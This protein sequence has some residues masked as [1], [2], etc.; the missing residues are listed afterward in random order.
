MT[1]GHRKN[2]PKT[3]RTI[4]PSRISR[5]A[6]SIVDIGEFALLAKKFKAAAKRRKIVVAAHASLMEEIKNNKIHSVTISTTCVDEFLLLQY[7]EQGRPA[8][9]ANGAVAAG[10]KS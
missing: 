9:T 7:S 4:H 8:H 5:V 10:A 6:T 1:A 2:P 3:L